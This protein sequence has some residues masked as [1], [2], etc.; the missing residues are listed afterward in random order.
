M[1]KP[2]RVCVCGRECSPR[3]P[4][5]SKFDHHHGSLRRAVGSKMCCPHLLQQFR[6]SKNVPL[7]LC[8]HIFQI[9]FI[10]SPMT[11]SF[12]IVFKNL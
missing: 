4:P 2:V 8:L 7:L 6:P 10:N 9:F 12:C 11:A 1:T 5:S 3:A